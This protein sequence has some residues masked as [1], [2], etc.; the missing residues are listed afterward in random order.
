MRIRIEAAICTKEGSRTVMRKNIKIG[1]KNGTRDRITES[2][3]FGALMI[4][5]MSKSGIIKN[6]VI[7]IINCCASFS[8]LTMEPT[9]A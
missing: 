9:A 4:K 7:G 1:A 3:L 8:E 5:I 2:E 6:M